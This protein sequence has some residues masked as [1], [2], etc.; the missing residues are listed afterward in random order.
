MNGPYTAVI[1]RIVDGE[2]AVL[3]LES[4]DG[5]AAQLDIDVELIPTDGRHEG[6]VFELSVGD[7]SVEMRYQPETE[8]DRRASAQ[9]RFDSL[10]KRLGD[11]GE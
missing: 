4:D 9:D 3:L 10:S 7:D 1:D 6:A 2:T 11:D 8:A 5:I